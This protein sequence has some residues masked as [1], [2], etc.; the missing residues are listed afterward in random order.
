MTKAMSVFR[1]N[2]L[3]LRSSSATRDTVSNAMTEALSHLAQA[4]LSYRIDTGFPESQE[5]IRCDFN[6]A[7]EAGGYA[8]LRRHLRHLDRQQFG[9]DPH[10]V[11]RP[12][13]AHRATGRLDRQGEQIHAGRHRA[14]RTE[15][16]QRGGCRQVDRGCPSR[17]HA[18]RRSRGAGGRGDDDDQK[19]SQEITRSST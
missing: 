13:R 3:D 6:R 19:S 4:D 18:G 11:G 16:R 15:R 9:P 17:R 5:Q 10:R 14:G 8:V 7:A 12:G 2:A 1:E